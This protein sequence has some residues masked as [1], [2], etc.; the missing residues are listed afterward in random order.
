MFLLLLN[1][2]PFQGLNSGEKSVGMPTQQ[3]NYS[4]VAGIELG[5]SYMQSMPYSNN[6]SFMIF[7]AHR[8]LKS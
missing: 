7:L 1:Y 8:K 6:F 4:G 2:N 3:F 5:A